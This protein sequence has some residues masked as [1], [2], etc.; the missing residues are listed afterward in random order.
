M[1][2]KWGTIDYLQTG[3]TRQQNAYQVLRDLRLFEILHEYEPILA[4]TIP[5][6]IDLED[7]DLDV[8]CHVGDF[9][10]F[11]QCVRTAFKGLEGFSQTRC[12]IDNK[13]TSLA[14]FL[15]RGFA[16]ELF[17]QAVESR[18]Q[19]AYRHMVMEDRLLSLGPPDMREHI[20]A[21]KKAGMKTE[22]AFMRYLGVMC[23]DPYAALLEWEKRSDSELKEK[24]S[25]R[26]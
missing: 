18:K 5:L 13:E 20:R 21:L 11:D 19:N 16:I 1:Q 10:A 23:T 15:Y 14:S 3:T 12:H 22:P 24:L 25:N 4:G 7:S 2:C 26:L 9:A 8:V 6:D 17:G